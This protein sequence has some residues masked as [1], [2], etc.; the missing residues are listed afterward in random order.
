MYT[1]FFN[2]Q[3]SRSDEGNT[4]GLS[5]LHRCETAYDVE[6]VVR[7]ISIRQT[8]LETAF[9]N[10]YNRDY[11]WQHPFGDWDFMVLYKG[12]L[13][14]YG[15]NLFEDYTDD[16]TQDDNSEIVLQEVPD[17]LDISAIKNTAI[18]SQRNLSKI[19]RAFAK[20]EKTVWQNFSEQRK[21]YIEE[22]RE[23]TLLANLLAKYPDVKV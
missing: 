13:Y 21:K 12:Y 18:E 10:R 2:R 14:H 23:R 7:N 11:D 9:V 5:E 8:R 20:S 4:D 15:C 6:Q 19:M 16:W 1:V 22:K 17:S 3:S